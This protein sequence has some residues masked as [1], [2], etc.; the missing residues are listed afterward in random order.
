MFRKSRLRRR[1]AKQHGERS[2]AKIS[3]VALYHI[4]WWLWRKLS[5]KKSLLV[6]YKILGVLVNTLT[7]DD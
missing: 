5:W 2:T 1:F 7:T 6:I 4:Y 3:T